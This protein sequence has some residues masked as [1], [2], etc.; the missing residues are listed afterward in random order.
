MDPQ[1]LP[2]PKAVADQPSDTANVGAQPAAAEPADAAA[3]SLAGGSSAEQHADPASAAQ[4]DAAAGSAAVE[5]EGV[6][7]QAPLTGSASAQQMAAVGSGAAAASGNKGSWRRGSDP[8]AA[9]V[10]TT[11][12]AAGLANS[13]QAEDDPEAS[14]GGAALFTQPQAGVPAGQAADAAGGEAPVAGAAS[15]A[16]AAAAATLQRLQQQ[17]NR[18]LD[19]AQVEAGISYVGHNARLRRLMRRLGRGE[20]ITLGV[21]IF[22]LIQCQVNLF[23]TTLQVLGPSRVAP[24]AIQPGSLLLASALTLG[25]CACLKVSGSISIVSHIG[26]AGTQARHTRYARA[27]ATPALWPVI[28]MTVLG[29]AGVVGGSISTC[30]D[31]T[32]G[33]HRMAFDWISRTF[34]AAAP[35]AHAF[36]NGA[37]GGIQSQYMTSCLKW[38]LPATVD[39][40]IVRAL[41]PVTTSRAPQ[42]PF[43][44]R[45]VFS[46][47]LADS[48]G[49]CGLGLIGLLTTS[50]ARRCCVGCRPPSPCLRCRWSSRSTTAARPST[51]RRCRARTSMAASTRPSADREQS[52]SMTSLGLLCSFASQRRDETD[53]SLQ[54]LLP[55]KQHR[56]LHGL[57]GSGVACAVRGQKAQWSAS[58]ELGP[59]AAHRYERLLR[60]LL[61]LPNRPAVILLQA[62]KGFVDNGRCAAWCRQGCKALQDPR[63]L[64]AKLCTGSQCTQLP[65]TNAIAFVRHCVSPPMRGMT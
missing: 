46:C 45:P 41:H 43:S 60:K 34:P 10:R 58:D 54:W 4:M 21:H 47:R 61:V 53:A 49:M 2:R 57:H 15:S 7:D 38:H 19:E 24:Q 65:P 37:T 48:P 35:A 27:L 26:G 63:N 13:L 59:T 50:Q 16:D 29:H 5:D 64:Q 23:V 18:V 11:I 17:P 1:E 55:S 9:A 20:G 33:Y 3:G 12:P 25:P 44:P 14:D 8:A 39:L 30:C 36:H 52:L 31:G 22:A 56:G 28:T 42:R 51:A 32:S 6:P 40:V 62:F